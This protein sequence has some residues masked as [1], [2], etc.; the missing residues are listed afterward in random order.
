M[1]YI[2]IN[3]GF[4]KV[5]NS[6]IL[7]IYKDIIMAINYKDEE[8]VFEITNGHLDGLREISNQYKIDG[9][10]KTLAFL[11]G[12]IREAK[13]RPITINGKSFEPSPDIKRK[14]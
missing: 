12:V 2:V 14:K 1:V 6:C 5:R 11:I 4:E 8:G 3:N 7:L 13:G 10:A 9:E